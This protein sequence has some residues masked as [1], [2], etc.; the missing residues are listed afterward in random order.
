VFILQLRNC[1]DEGILW[2]LG[3][4][5]Y[6]V[7]DGVILLFVALIELLGLCISY[8]VVYEDFDCL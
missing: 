2:F 1:V 5:T 4:S 7:V 6:F 3:C 8:F